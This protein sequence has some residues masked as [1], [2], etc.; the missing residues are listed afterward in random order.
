[1]IRVLHIFNIMD[2]AGAETM[3]MNVYRNI[4]RNKIQFDF[5]CMEKRKGD[6]DDEIKSLGGKIYR[7]DSPN[8][9]RI[10]NLIQIYKIMKS[11]KIKIIHSHMSFY[12]GPLCM[13]A[14]WSGVNKIIVHSHTT[15]DLRKVGFIRK[16]YNKLCRKLISKYAT[17]KL[18]C[19]EMAGKYL[20]IDDKFTIIKN[21]IDLEKY[22]NVTEKQ[23]NLLKKELNIND[24]LIIGHVGRFVE[25]KN[26]EYFIKLA[27][28][29]K[30]KYINFKIVLVGDGNLR[31]NIKRKIKDE[32]LEQYFILP[33]IRENINVFMQ[34][35]SLFILPSLY[36]GFPLVVVEALAGK[37]KCFISNKV[38][39]ETK[40][41]DEMVEFF[42][43]DDNIENMVDKILINHE[44]K[45]NCKINITKE[46]K[47][48]SIK[49]ISEK[50]EKIYLN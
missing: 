40:I 34:M 26:Q 27:K 7:V 29:L 18:A 17:I 50:M 11:E 32:K 2:R 16:I 21:G 44:Y 49:D 8:K 43:I 14:K 48:F 45:K 10:K 6:Y 9:G 36:E 19:G 42:D 4:D 46:L 37:N 23:V 24:E 3:I 39:S 1:M 25:V 47:D 22:I 41:I 35:F 31:S 33:G 20:Y 30:D 38:S 12:S 28:K 13:V 5:I 15:S